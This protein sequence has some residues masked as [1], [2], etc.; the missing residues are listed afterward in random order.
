MKTLTV[1]RVRKMT[2]ALDDHTLKIV[3]GLNENKETARL[4][5]EASEDDDY[6]YLRVVVQFYEDSEPLPLYED[7][8]DLAT[9]IS[10]MGDAELCVKA[11]YLL[12]D[13]LRAD[14]PD[15]DLLLDNEGDDATVPPLDKAGE[16]DCDEEGNGGLWNLLMDR[17]DLTD[18]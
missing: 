1:E 8:L 14:F 7:T 3:S 10:D 16:Q 17:G 2:I 5:I 13:T 15:I 6:G 18:D 11:A 9:F 12:Y 4:C